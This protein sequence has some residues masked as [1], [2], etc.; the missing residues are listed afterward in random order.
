MW[1]EKSTNELNTDEISD[2]MSQLRR[3]GVRRIG[4]SGGEPLLRQDLSGLIEKAHELGFERITVLSN[5]LLWNGA[6]AI[7]LLESGLSAVSISVDGL[8]ET[9]DSCRGV[10]GAY[11]KSIEALKIL[12]NLR[13][14]AYFD[15]DILMATTLMKPTIGQATTL[16]KMAKELGVNWTP[17]LFENVSFQFEGIDAN[18]LLIKDQEEMDRLISELHEMKRTY[19]ISNAVTHAGLE[20]AR[21]YPKGRNS[22]KLQKA[23][24]CIAGFTSIYIDA[25]GRVYSG[26]WALPPLGKLGERTLKEIT[27]TAEYKQRLQDMFLRKCP[28][29]T[30][31]YMMCTWY[32]IP[33][34]LSEALWI[35]RARK[36]KSISQGFCE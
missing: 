4:F 31:S 32:H 14:K 27:S 13:D 22:A 34:I 10:T 20:L 1:K 25:Y 17:N 36:P 24:P 26:C 23:P 3:M 8:E 9:H 35:L 33:S 28:F 5:G 6:K 18:P 7:E 16:L 19:P 15:L 2:I 30:N 12:A 21:E 29:C 11:R